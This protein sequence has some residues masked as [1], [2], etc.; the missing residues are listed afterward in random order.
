[1]DIRPAYNCLLG[2]PCIHVARTVP[3]S[4]HQKVKFIVGTTGVE[5]EQEDSKPLR[6]AI[7]AARVP[8]QRDV[9]G[10]QD[11]VLASGPQK[12]FSDI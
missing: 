3:S 11:V 12:S 10:L 6:A 1:M 8:N 7:M 2:T 5:M 9:Q 4:F